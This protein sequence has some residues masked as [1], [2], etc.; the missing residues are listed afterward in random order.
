M[1]ERE[2][3]LSAAL[4]E[5]ERRL[6]ED[7]API[8]RLVNEHG[9]KASREAWKWAIYGSAIHAQVFIGAD[10]KQRKQEDA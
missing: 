6:R 7:T 5:I 1:T 8:L 10:E 9:D 3:E 4:V 2:R